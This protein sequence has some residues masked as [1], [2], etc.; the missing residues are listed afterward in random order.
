MCFMTG[1]RHLTSSPDVNWNREK[2]KSKELLTEP[3]TAWT[4]HREGLKNLRAN[5]VNSNSSK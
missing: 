4:A 5:A 2:R 3:Q 1:V